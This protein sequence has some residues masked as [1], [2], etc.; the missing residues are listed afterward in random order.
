MNK[1]K[2]FISF[3]ALIIFVSSIFSNPV[4]AE[5]KS[6]DYYQ[7]LGV[8]I[9]KGFNY[10]N[11][12][13]EYTFDKKVAKENSGLSDQQIDKVNEHLKTLD[14]QKLNLLQQDKLKSQQNEDGV[15]TEALPLLPLIGA[16]AIGIVAAVGTTVASNFAD[17]IYNYGLTTAC[18]NFK[19]YK[20]I[21][22][23]CVINKYI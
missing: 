18:K 15:Q 6:G 21:K 23:F 16:A 10:D 20:A 14:S 19:K 22:D 13:G 4:N 3:M 17:D 1:F 2:I 5:M 8:K 11:K 7:D 12:S 9:L